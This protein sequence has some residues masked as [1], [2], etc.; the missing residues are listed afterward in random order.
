ME[1][2]RSLLVEN[3]MASFLAND[4]IGRMETCASQDDLGINRKFDLSVDQ[5]LDVALMI[6]VRNA[7]VNFCNQC[8]FINSSI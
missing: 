3:G 4:D 8:L 2:V 7:L 6:D 1:Q 5:D